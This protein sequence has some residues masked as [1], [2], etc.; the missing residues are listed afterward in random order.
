MAYSQRSKVIWKTLTSNEDESGSLVPGSLEDLLSRATKDLRLAHQSIEQLQQQ[1]VA[2]GPGPKPNQ[3]AQNPL[4]ARR[5]A[6]LEQDAR[7]LQRGLEMAGRRARKEALSLGRRLRTLLE[8]PGEDYDLWFLLLE[9]DA[10]QGIGFST[11]RTLMVTFGRQRSEMGYTHNGTARA[12]SVDP[13]LIRKL[14][15]GSLRGST[16]FTGGKVAM[17]ALKMLSDGLT[18]NCPDIHQQHQDCKLLT[19]Q[20]LF[21]GFFFNYFFALRLPCFLE[22]DTNMTRI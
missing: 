22:Y 3:S 21:G 7:E 13:L 20:L 1:W 9:Q 6:M 11:G 4:H 2:S 17:I 15:F 19:D 18:N 12:R 10:L 14:L 16:V 5:L 8:P